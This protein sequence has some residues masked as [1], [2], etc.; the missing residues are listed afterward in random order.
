DL[1]HPVVSGG[2]FGFER[3]NVES[4][5]RQPGSL[6]DWTMRMIR[7]RKRCP[8]IGRGEWQIL[9]TRN[10]HVIA[11]HYEWRGTRLVTVHNLSRRQ[12]TTKF[13]VPGSERVDLLDL[14]HDA[15]VPCANDGR[16]EIALP[17]YGYCWF[18]VGSLGPAPRS[19]KPD[20]EP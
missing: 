7:M 16:Y 4:Q 6:L 10:P 11:M 2:P 5:W 8:A 1:V 18:R 15:A 14:L 20:E 3:V 13:Q 12:A 17:A 9:S 19:P